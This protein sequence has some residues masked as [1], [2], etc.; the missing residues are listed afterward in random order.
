MLLLPK[1]YKMKKLIK[2]AGLFLLLLATILSGAVFYLLHDLPSLE[3][4]TAPHCVSGSRK[5]DGSNIDAHE[6]TPELIAM[7]KTSNP[8]INMQGIVAKELSL[9]MK[10]VSMEY[11]HLRGFLIQHIWLS[12]FDE[13]RLIAYSLNTAY[14]GNGCYGIDAAAKS[15]FKKDFLQLSTEELAKLIATLRAP[16]NYSIIDK[17]DKNSERATFL[18]KQIKKD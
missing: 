2:F 6:L 13:N 7:V 5:L 10:Q 17:P 16:N 14:F 8:N 9:K 11:H 3:E 18:L 12:Q 1:V 4:H 15:F